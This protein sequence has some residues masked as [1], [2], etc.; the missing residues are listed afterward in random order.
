[1]QRLPSL[2]TSTAHRTRVLSTISTAM[3]FID[4]GANLTDGMFSGNYHGKQSHD[5]DVDAVIA[6]ARSSGVVRTLVTAGTLSQSTEAASLCAQYPSQLWSTAGVH[7]TRASEAGATADAQTSYMSQVR[8][9]ILQSSKVIAIGECGLDYDRLQFATRAEQLPVFLAHFSLAQ[10]MQKPL[11][12][13]NRNTGGDFARVIRE[14]RARFGDGVVHSF[15]GSCEELR[16]LIAL[17]LYIGVNGCSLKTEANLA[18]VREIPLGRLML[19]TD[20]PYCGIKRSHASHTHV[21]SAF[22]QVDKKKHSR[23]K[24]VKGRCEP[25]QILQVCEVV[26]AVKGIPEEEVARSAFNNTMR[27][28]FPKEAA[29][30]GSSPYD[31][32]MSAEAN[33]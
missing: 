22:A 2:R 16:E 17:G 20:A 25:C 23:E 10:E 14:N 33:T 6:R 21:R 8:D 11:F 15:T 31:L 5:A 7:P 27:V 26:A 28:F 12:L 13:H 29:D 19:E 3:H 32:S 4:I 1:M 18:A 30:M 24:L 9:T